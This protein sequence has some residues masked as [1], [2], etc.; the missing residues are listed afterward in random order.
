[1]KT[2]LTGREERVAFI[3][4]LA[5]V[6]FASLDTWDYDDIVRSVTLARKIRWETERQLRDEHD[7]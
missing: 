7:W 1:M 4:Q 3:A 2:S 6:L 5:A